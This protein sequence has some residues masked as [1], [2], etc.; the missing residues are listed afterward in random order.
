LGQTKIKEIYFASSNSNKYREIEQILTQYGVESHFVKMSLQEIQSE[1]VHQIAKAKSTNAFE[2][3]QKPVIIE[4]DG[5]YISSLKGFPG[6]YSSFVYKTLG[7]QGLL[8]LMENRTN[9][10]ACFLSV[11]AYNDGHKLKMFTGKTQ[12]MLNRLATDGG[13]GFDPIFIPENTTKTYGELSQL[14]RKALFSHRHKSIKKFS[15]W[16]IKTCIQYGNH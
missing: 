3:L 13:W 8:K 1:S 11:I 15:K 6:Q 16:Y 5:F 14:N 12:G 2:Y 10:K 9:R 4:D 7:N